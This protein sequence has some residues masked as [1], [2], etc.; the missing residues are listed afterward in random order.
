MAK[1]QAFDHHSQ[2]H[3]LHLLRALEVMQRTIFAILSQAMTAGFT[4]NII[5]PYNG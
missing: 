2:T 1:A 3:L 5:T 4:S